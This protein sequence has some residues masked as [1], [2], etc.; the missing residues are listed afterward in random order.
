VP[1]EAPARAER[2]VRALEDTAAVGPGGEVAQRAGWD[3]DEPGG[4]IQLELA[5]VALAQLEVDT[6]SGCPL[7][8]LREHRRRRVDSEHLPSGLARDRDRDAAIPDRELDEW[9]VRLPGELDV[10]RDVL[11]H[12]RRPVV[13]DRREGVVGAHV[14]LSLA[15]D[16]ARAA[17]VYAAPA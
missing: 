8:R 6:S 17:A 1:G 10:E 9:P 4:L 5:H 11:G 13:V 7:A 3:V 12:V 16:H 2:R 14:A 15:R